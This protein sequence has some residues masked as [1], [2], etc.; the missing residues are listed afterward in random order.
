MDRGTLQARRD[1]EIRLSTLAISLSWT[2]LLLGKSGEIS[3]T[4]Y[5]AVGSAIMRLSIFCS[6]QNQ[7]LMVIKLERL[8]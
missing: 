3:H 5:E 7:M 1:Q 2:P 4:P 6:I 8:G